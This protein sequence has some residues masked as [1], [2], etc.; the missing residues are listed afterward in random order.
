[1]RQKRF[2]SWLLTLC[3]LLG[4]FSFSA[5]AEG[6]TTTITQDTTNQQGT[7]TITLVIPK[8]TPAAIDL[9][10]TAPSDLTYNRDSDKTATVAAASGVTGMGDITVK[11][12]SD[13]A[14]STEVTETKNVG[15]YYVGVTVAEGDEYAASTAV[16]YGDNW[17]FEITK[18]TP[19]APAAP[20]MASATKNSIKLNAVSGCEYSINGTSWQSGTEFTGLAPGTEYTFYQR[21]GATSNTNASPASSAKFS[22]EADTYAMTITLVIKSTQTITAEDVTATY[23]DTDKSVSATA[24]G[25]ISYKVKDG[26]G[27]YISVNESTGALTIKKVPPTDGKAYVIVTAAETDDYAEA[28]KEVV[29][30]ISPAEVTVTAKDQSIYVGGMV[31]TLSGSDFYTVTGLVGEDALTTAPTLTYQK[32][33]SAATPDNT[34]AGTYDIVPS[35]ASAGDNY[36]ISYTNGALTISAKNVQTITA[37]DV[38]VTYG[39]TDKKITATTNGDGTISYAVKSGSEN[40]IE[41]A[42]DGK[43]TIKAVPADGKAY[44]TVTASE[45]ATYAQATK[46]VTVTINKT[47]AVPA[48]VTSNT[49]TYNGQE[50]ALVTVDN[51]TLVGGTMQYAIGTATEATEPYTTSIPAKTNAGTYYVWYKVEG[52]SNHNGTEPANVPVSISKAEATIHAADQYIHVGDAVPALAEPVLNTHYTVT[53]LVGEDKLTTAPTLAYQKDGSAAEPDN[54]TAGTYDIVPS[55]ASA[56][57][58]YTIS[59]GNGTL[60]ISEKAVQVISASDVAAT[61]G[62]TGKSV[63]ASV[64]TPATGGGAISYAVKSGDAVA[65]DASTGALTIVKAGNAVV[66]VTA[67][68]TAEYAKVTKDVNVTVSRKAVTVTAAD[69]TVKEGESIATGADKATLAGALEGHV[70]SGVTLAADTEKK[71]IT[72][73][74]AVIKD[75]AGNDVSGN[76][77][78]TYTAGKLTVIGKISFTVTF[79]VAN[80]AW[81]DGKTEDKIVTLAG[82]E[83]DTL[84][85]KET[86]IPAVGTKPVEGYQVGAWDTVPAADTVITTNTVYT[87]NYAKNPEPEANIDGEGV[88]V[89]EDTD[90]GVQGIDNT[91]IGGQMEEI[92]GADDTAVGENQSKDVKVTLEVQ[93][94][95]EEKVPENEK[96]AINNAVDGVIPEGDKGT[97]KGDFLDI[98]VEKIVVVYD[99]NENG[100]KKENETIRTQLE[101]LDKVADIPVKYDLSE[102]HN[103]VVVRFHDGKAEVFTRLNE[104]PA[105]PQDG[106]YYIEGSGKDAVIHIYTNLFS[107]YAIFTYGEEEHTEQMVTITFDANGGTGQMAPVKVLKGTKYTLPECGFTA[108]ANQVFDSW[109][110]GEPGEEIEI[111]GDTVITAQWALDLPQKGLVMPP[112]VAPKGTDGITI[113]WDAM[114]GAEGYDVFVSPCNKNAFELCKSVSANEKRSATVIGLKKGSA[115]KAYVRGWIMDGDTKVYINSSAQRSH[116]IVGGSTKSVTTPAKV[117]VKRAEITIE[118]GRQETINATVKGIKPKLRILVHAG[119]GMRWYSSNASVATVDGEGQVTAVKEGKCTIYAVAINGKRAKVKVT[120][121]PEITE[122]KV[123]FEGGVYQLNKAH[124]AATFVG[125]AKKNVKKLTIADEVVIGGKTFPVTEIK[126]SACKGLAKLEEVTIGKN[127]QKIGKEAFRDCKKAK[128]FTVLTEKLTD[129]AVGKNAFKTG[130]AATY[131]CP[132]GMAKKYKKLIMKK[133]AKKGSK[134][135]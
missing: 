126:A 20:I 60:T 63:S 34:T 125:A 111:T 95:K 98:S 5:F 30:T 124:T 56:G 113:T 17:T 13:A 53:G 29:V 112:V 77:E 19:S 11:Y 50:Q 90:S 73:S 108:P 16:L 14:R 12:Y 57:D 1:M 38:T 102:K 4:I 122:T 33:G 66:T 62:D 105:T 24:S 52:D 46:E 18:S 118:A 131:K 82:H 40:Y 35:G 26:S 8:K 129:K 72:A 71:E 107:T 81:D 100:E 78:A 45:T 116:V 22:T 9:T 89:N 54:T 48:T 3:L 117:S 6:N 68:E 42:S 121:I 25:A 2:L 41:I 84:K 21:K 10:Y 70:L 83:G 76:Y 120:V 103:P 92:A 97:L 88:F 87:Y 86:D 79:R 93:S 115:C 104:A 65:V 80:G 64:T 99:V 31:P 130:K 36:N 49:L 59:Y 75:A 23:G 101:K 85:L 110:A 61:Y 119:I 114:N 44:V 74:G 58:N 127:V 32:D 133:G 37:S 132:K 91:S 28:T 39:D 128:T 109:D 67:A 96:A 43:L 94:A 69:Q 106:T 27:D 15:T 47:D 55:G 51:S 7:M 135:R 134:F 123:T